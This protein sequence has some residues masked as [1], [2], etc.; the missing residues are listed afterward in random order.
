MDTAPSR[1][2]S[3]KLGGSLP[4]HAPSYVMRSADQEFYEG[5]KAGEFCYVFNSRQMGK[6]SLRV[7]TIHRL[8]ADGIA[9]G[10]ID[11]TGIGIQEVTPQQW[12][13]SL[14]RSLVS[15]FRLQLN[16]RTWWRE[17]DHL[18]CVQRL[19][20]F[21]EEVLLVEVEQNIVIF[22]DEIDSVLGLSFPIDDFF[23]WIRASY[24]KRARQPAYRRLT[25]A[26]LGVATP[27][28][29]IADKNRTPFN[30]GRAIQLNGFE[31][32]TFRGGISL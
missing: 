23:A 13:A 3:Y 16:L 7:Q 8:Q 27:S 4:L 11:V 32:I 26:L 5:L 28:N 12:Y 21:V 2:Y 20:E 25:F 1:N 29:L 10:V 6:S 18:S 22:I 15:S 14:L 17:R 19:N 30:I 31:C 24:D 9:C